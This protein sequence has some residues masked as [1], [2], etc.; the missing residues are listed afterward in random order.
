MNTPPESLNYIINLPIHSLFLCINT[1][2]SPSVR[3]QLQ[4]ITKI[5]HLLNR[6]GTWRTAED[7]LQESGRDRRLSSRILQGELSTAQECIANAFPKIFNKKGARQPPN[8]MVTDFYS[9]DEPPPD[10][11]LR[12]S[13]SPDLFHT[14]YT[15]SLTQRSTPYHPNQEHPGT[16]TSCSHRTAFPGR[17][18]I[19]SPSPRKKDMFSTG[20][21]TKS[22]HPRECYIT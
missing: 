9:L 17:T 22:Y 12:G 5:G 3:L 6:S 7:F 20:C 13:L 14:R 21:F 1:N 15:T 18:Y 8:E 10:I 19:V 2:A 4:K 11:R 16:T